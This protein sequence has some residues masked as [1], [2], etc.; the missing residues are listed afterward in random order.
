MVLTAKPV[1]RPRSRHAC[2]QPDKV[3]HNPLK[4]LRTHYNC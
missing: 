1:N 3:Y 2:I 4:S